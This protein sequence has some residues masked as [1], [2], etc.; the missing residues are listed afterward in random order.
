METENRAKEDIIP[1]VNARVVNSNS[2]KKEELER[3]AMTP[4]VST[5]GT[6]A[7]RVIAGIMDNMI[8]LGLAIL[9]AVYVTE[10]WPILQIIA[11]VVVYLGYYFLFEG[12]F[13]RTIGKLLTG[14]VVIQFDGTQCTWSKTS[15][16]TLFRILE[17]NPVLLGAIPAVLSIIMGKHHQRFGDKVAGTLVVESYLLRKKAS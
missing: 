8:A 14:L 13:S 1:V 3:G 15:I 7:P 4:V 5:D 10:D 2:P 6:V 11:F 12:F 16:R 9:A 17:V